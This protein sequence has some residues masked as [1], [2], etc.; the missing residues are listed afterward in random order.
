[1]ADRI[2]VILVNYHGHADTIECLESLLKSSYPSFQIV[3]VDNSLDFDSINQIRLWAEGKKYDAIPTDFPEYVFPLSTKPV[4][5]RFLNE[6]EFLD[7]AGQLNEKILLVKSKDNR[8]FAGGNN[9]GLAYFLKIPSFD[10]A[11]LLN[12]DTVVTADTL[13]NFVLFAASSKAREGIFGGKLFNYFDRM[14]LQ[15][16]GGR[17]YRWFG[18]VREIGSGKQDNGQWDNRKFDFDYVVGAC[19]F[20]KR[21]FV[22]SIGKMNEDYFLYY[23][24]IDWA[25]RGER[26]GW[27]MTF[28][29]GAVVFHKQGI[30]TGSHAG[31][32][33]ELSDFYSVRNRIL[34][35]K[36]YFPITLLT[37]YPSFLMFAF[38][39]LKLMKFDR[40]ALLAKLILVPNSKY[41]K[42]AK[43]KPD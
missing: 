9:I 24:E 36:K 23:E 30:S 10:Y 27:E 41:K 6:D 40:L 39:R 28:C 13:E 37:L 4:S 2:C 7:I 12:N 17:Y 19:M 38:N 22:E 32:V 15:A 25:I 11:W 8:G 34:L 35:A 18:K 14:T 21:S 42:T 26:E 33:S 43:I 31:E 16:V 29:P 3:I 20:L 1:M 5:Y